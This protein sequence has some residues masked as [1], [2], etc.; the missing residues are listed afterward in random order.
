M[1]WAGVGLAAFAAALLFLAG[2]GSSRVAAVI[3]LAAVVLIGLSS[4]LRRSGDTDLEEVLL[5]EVDMVRQNV[6]TDIASAAKATHRAF[7][8]KLQALHES[9]ETIRGE[10]AAIQHTETVRVTTRQTFVDQHADGRSRDPEHPH[11]HAWGDGRT[12]GDESRTYGQERLPYGDERRRHSGGGRQASAWD[13]D[14]WIGTSG[15]PGQQ[16]RELQ[17]GERHTVVRSDQTGTQMRIEDRW[18][19]MREAPRGAAPRREPGG[20][21]GAETGWGRD[22][23]WRQQ[24][25]RSQQPAMDQ[26]PIWGQQP[27]GHHT[28]RDEPASS[29]R[30]YWLPPQQA[31][32]E[33]AGH[34]GGHR[35]A[36]PGGDDRG[37]GDDYGGHRYWQDHD[38]GYGHGHGYDYGHGD[39]GYGR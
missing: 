13:D 21:Q 38:P 23:S 30:Q 39:Y 8:E 28:L 10:V 11:H 25:A 5:D 18:A 29:W 33:Q 2:G 27:A 19:S 22:L 35:R 31:G 12:Y 32:P 4:A 15:P 36:E 34:R 24:P 16:G 7:G 1:S 9:I 6:R 26:Q 20:D 14:R 37:Y 17:I 3:A